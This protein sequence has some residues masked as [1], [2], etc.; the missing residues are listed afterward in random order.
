MLCVVVGFNKFNLSVKRQSQDKS[1]TCGAAHYNA[2]LC[3]WL[4]ALR[5]WCMTVCLGWPHLSQL[6]STTHGP[7]AMQSPHPR[8]GF[9]VRK[10]H[11]EP[12]GTTMVQEMQV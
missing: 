9:Q 10:R 2:T 11:A 7:W 4:F 8:M 1:G 5:F 12:Q 6:Y 3:S